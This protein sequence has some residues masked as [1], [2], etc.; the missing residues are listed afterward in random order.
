MKKLF[1]MFLAIITL[2][3][4]SITASAESESEIFDDATE[5][6]ESKFGDINK[7]GKVTA[8]DARLLLRVAANLEKNSPYILMYGDYNKDGE[9]TASD[10]R[11]ALRVAADLESMECVLHGHN[12]AEHTVAPTCTEI[13]YTTQKCS[14]CNY[15][16]DEKANII[17]ATGHD[18]SF[19]TIATNATCIEAGYKK[20]FCHCGV[21]DEYITETAK[22]HNMQVL[23]SVKATCVSDGYTEY[24]CSECGH[25]EKRNVTKAGGHD[26]KYVSTKLVRT[27]YGDL[28]KAEK[29]CSYCNNII[30]TYDEGHGNTQV[31]ATIIHSKEAFA[32]REK[33]NVA[34]P[35]EGTDITGEKIVIY[36][37]SRGIDAN[38]YFYNL[39]GTL[40][41]KCDR[42]GKQGGL[43][44]NMCNITFCGVT[45]G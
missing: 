23:K 39:D 34:Y 28:I 5:F 7:D 41:G 44:K 11:T 18:Y 40:Y 43:G 4:I 24:K 10:A 25:T 14:R 32:I 38:G 20:M 37:T 2:F 29:K 9:I 27:D 30:T 1:I 35:I 15:A 26:Y 42:C 45:F 13:G 16:T 36:S 31:P 21:F 8:S 33:Y 17:N 19:N 22:G 6:D 3:A 12:L